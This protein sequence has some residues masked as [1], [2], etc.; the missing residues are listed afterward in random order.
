MRSSGRLSKRKILMSR[1]SQL[2]GTY[3]AV[4]L[5][6]LIY[7]FRGLSFLGFPFCLPV[8]RKSWWRE[9]E[10]LD[11]SCKCQTHLFIVW[12]WLKFFV[13]S[14]NYRIWP[15]APLSPVDPICIHAYDMC[16]S[17]CEI[18]TFEYNLN[19]CKYEGCEQHKLICRNIVL[20]WLVKWC[21]FGFAGESSIWSESCQEE[22]WVW[23]TYECLQ[24]E[25]GNR[26]FSY[27]FR[28]PHHVSSCWKFS[29]EL[30]LWSSICC[31]ISQESS[32]D[33]GEGDEGSEKSASEV[34]DDDEE[35][36]QVYLQ[37]LLI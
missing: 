17:Y 21:H 36:V 34:H 3:S 24:Q 22:G 27:I 2:Y 9:V 14:L 13:Q 16:F 10:I 4:I 18:L 26:I 8:G 32:A 37:C 30:H 1:P 11:P 29:F 12:S 28:F 25:A 23:K 20:V 6:I 5:I 7:R 35:S 19:I 31:L 33:E 15:E